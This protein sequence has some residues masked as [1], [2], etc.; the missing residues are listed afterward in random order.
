M[1]NIDRDLETLRAIAVLRVAGR[2]GIDASERQVRHLLR[3]GLGLPETLDALRDT[4]QAEP[5]PRWWP[6][7]K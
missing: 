7:R 5:S 2:C 3:S 6:V 1:T 4:R